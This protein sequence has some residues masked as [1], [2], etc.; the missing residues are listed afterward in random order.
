[1]GRLALQDIASLYNYQSCPIARCNYLP[2]RLE[3]N[4]EKFGGGKPFF[5]QYLRKTGST[6]KYLCPD[7]S[8]TMLLLLLSSCHLLL[9]LELSHSTRLGS[10]HTP[11]SFA[12]T[13]GALR[14]LVGSYRGLQER[15][16]RR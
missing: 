7:P 6:L 13:K 8:D 3:V 12:Q 4:V 5:H 14:L 11:K 15:K 16:Q 2:V 10:I 1:M 9:K